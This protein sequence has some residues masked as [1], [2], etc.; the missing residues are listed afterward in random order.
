MKQRENSVEEKNWKKNRKYGHVDKEREREDNDR[1]SLIVNHEEDTCI[2][3]SSRKERS[4][5]WHFL[6]SR[7]FVYLVPLFNSLVFFFFFI[8][9]LLFF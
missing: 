1:F 3:V 6:A 5:S 8:F 7:I 2:D 9:N 4:P